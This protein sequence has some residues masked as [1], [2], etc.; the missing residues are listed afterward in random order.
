MNWSRSRSDGGGEETSSQDQNH[1]ENERRW[2]QERLHREEAY[3]RFINDL[4]DEDYRLMRDHNL[5]GTPGEITSEEL[6]QRLDGVKEQ[7]A[8]QPDLRNGTNTRDSGVPRE[9]SN[10]DSLLEWL[11]TFRRTGN[12]TRSGQNGN[13]TWRAVSR[14]NPHS[15]EFRFSLEIHINHETRGFE[16]DGEDYVGVPLSDV[17]QDSTTDG[18]QRSSS[19]VA[20]RTRSQAAGNL[21]GSSASVPRTRLGPRGWNSVEGSLSALGRL[22]NGIGGAVGVPR[23]SAPRAN[24]SSPSAGSELR[25]REGQRFGAAH[26][27]ENGARTNVTV[28]N[29]NQRLEPIRLRSTFNSRSRSPIQRQSGTVYHGS[30]RESRPFQQTSRRSVRR[31]G[32][33]RVFLE[34]DREGRGTAYTPLSNSRLVSRITVE[35]GEEASRSSTAARRHPTITLDLQVRRIRPG[36]SRD[37]DSIANRTRSRVGLAENTVTIESS[38]GGFRRTISRLERS[39]MRTYVS[40]VTVPLRR[41]SENELVEPSSVALRSILRQIMTGFGELS[42]LMEAESESEAQ[43]SGQHRPETHSEVSLLGETVSQHRGGSSQGRRTREDSPDTPPRAPNRGGRQSRN[44]SN[45][46]ETGTLPILRLAHFFLLNE[47]EDDD[48]MRGL[49]KEQIDNLSTRNYEHSSIDSELGKICS[50]CISDY[51]T[52]NKL[53]QLPCMHEFHIHCIDRWLSENCTCPICR[54][55]VLGSS[56]ANNG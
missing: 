19:P 18:P 15:G 31:R 25:Q 35:E 27:W 1:H 2:Q 6:Q 56:T 12:A 30:Q 29:T 16:M 55:P 45:L 8:S 14:T 47:G 33:T 41:I 52:G 11:N 40:T 42:S 38:S 44:S 21:S 46:V 50:V 49:T 54:Q 43:R 39:G 7:L 9:S 10:E 26:V 3:Y 37:R 4:N 13:Q 17:S 22:R 5:F 28:R 34:Q 23:T 53:R 32:I 51:V 48:R 36:E 24:F 20:R